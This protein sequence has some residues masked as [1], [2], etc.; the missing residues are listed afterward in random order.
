MRRREH[1]LG[2][3]FTRV[4][5]SEFEEVLPGSSLPRRSE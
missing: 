4:V 3:H 2:P 5:N 1:R